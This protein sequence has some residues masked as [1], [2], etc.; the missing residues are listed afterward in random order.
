M[1][2]VRRAS[3]SLLTLD[4]Y[5]GDKTKAASETGTDAFHVILLFSVFLLLAFLTLGLDLSMLNAL[6]TKMSDLDIHIKAIHTRLS[7][8]LLTL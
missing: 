5:N 2:D 6:Q 8:S 7:F 1:W 3:S 4:Q